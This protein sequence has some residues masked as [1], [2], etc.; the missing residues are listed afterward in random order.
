MGGSLREPSPP[1]RLARRNSV[2]SLTRR[3]TPG[4]KKSPR[5][6]AKPGDLKIR[7]GDAL[8]SRAPGRSIIT[9]CSLNGRVRDGNGCLPAAKATNPKGEGHATLEEAIDAGSRDAAAS[10]GAP[11]P[12]GRTMSCGLSKSV[13]LPV[14]AGDPGRRAHGRLRGRPA[15]LT[16]YQNQ[17]AERLAALRPLTCRPGSLPG[18]FRMLAHWDEPSPGVLGA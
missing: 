2:A 17:S 6:R 8:L 18:A 10:G 11:P 14:P 12:G 4:D 13:F 9:A 3:F 15:S 5:L 1:P 16:A 7:I